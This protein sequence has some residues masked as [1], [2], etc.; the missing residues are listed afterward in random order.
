MTTQPHVVVVG[1]GIGGMTAALLIAR[2]GASVTLLERVAEPAAVGAGLL[3]QPNGLA[4]LDGLGLRPALDE[5]GQAIRA[6][7]VRRADGRLLLHAPIRDHGPGLDHALAV[8]R[9]ELHRMLH[10]AISRS[11][12]ITTRLGAD[13]VS[14]DPAGVVHLAGGEPSVTGDLVVGADGVR[15]AVRASG[16]FGT[17]VTST[18]ATYVRA[19]VAGTDHGLQGEYWTRLG[20][21]GGAPLGDGT[22][23][24]YAAAHAPPVAAALARRDLPALQ[25]LWSEELA[26]AASLLG[27]VSTYDDLLVNDVARVDAERWSHGA[28]VLLGDAAHAMSPT[29]GQ[30]ANSAIVDAAVLADELD[31]DGTVDDAVARY[32]RRRQ[33]SVRKVQDTADRVAAL[34][35]APNSWRTSALISMLRLAAHSGSIA[36]R[37][38]R[39]V[40]QEDPA[41][42][43]ET[44]TVLGGG[45]PPAPGGQ[46]PVSA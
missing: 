9:S 7:D 27:A 20:L 4:V 22:T 25:A 13:V 39:L 38:D 19:I 15:S 36:A 42:L 21:F 23:Y 8:R 17:V 3:L 6:A 26:P 16:D 24:F 32:V 43:R 40:Q 37:Q 35:D 45:K 14:V 2:T 46:H 11:G 31:Q 1:A 18:G 34:S 28:S 12:R 5:A 41:L 30:G 29:L 10:D 33:A 44:V